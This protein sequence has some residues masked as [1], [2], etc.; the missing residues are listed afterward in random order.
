M[1]RP[2]VR[3]TCVLLTEAVTIVGVR[4]LW[5]DG[6]ISPEADTDFDTDNHGVLDGMPDGVVFGIQAVPG[7]SSVS[8]PTPVG[9]VL[10]GDRVGYLEGEIAEEMHPLIMQANSIG[11]VVRMRARMYPA[12]AQDRRL[13]LRGTWPSHLRAW[14]SLP[15]QLRGSEFFE[16]EWA[17]ALWGEEF[18]LRRHAV[19]GQADQ[20]ITDCRLQLCDGASAIDVYVSEVHVAIVVAGYSDECDDVVRRV[21]A[22]QLSGYAKLRRLDGGHIVVGITVADPGSGAGLQRRGVPFLWPDEREAVERAERDRIERARV[23]GLVDGKDYRQWFEKVRALKRAGKNKAAIRLLERMLDA[24]DAAS[25][26]IEAAPLVWITEQAAIVYRKLNNLEA[27]V[28]VLQRYLAHFPPGRAPRKITS[29]LET[30]LK[31][32]HRSTETV[33]SHNN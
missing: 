24:E 11:F 20:L 7:P 28:A 23:A 12:G 10:D 8:E 18:Q 29:R 25:A 17:R 33:R 3:L 32:L 16:I 15:A 6:S 26:I 5:L 30:A 4:D 9:L 2:Q 1:A 13:E 21:G 27:E 22:G 14:L 31:L 19:L